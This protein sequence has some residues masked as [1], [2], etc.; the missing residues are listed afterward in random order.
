MVRLR[1]RAIDRRA[2]AALA[3]PL[4]GLCRRVG[5]ILQAWN[6]RS[7]RRPP[8]GE[9]RSRAAIGGTKDHLAEVESLAGAVAAIV[10][11]GC[12]NR[13]R[14]DSAPAGRSSCGGRRTRRRRGA[15]AR[16]HPARVRRVPPG[17][18]RLAGAGH[19]ARACASAGPF[20]P[21]RWRRTERARQQNRWRANASTTRARSRSVSP[22]EESMLMPPMMATWL[23]ASR[24]QPVFA[25]DGHPDGV[26]RSVPPSPG[27]AP[28]PSQCPCRRA[29]G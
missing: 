16:R 1:P 4:L 2:R 20:A 28:I 10:T 5:V 21:T 8:H 7:G 13:D 26:G 18:G 22:A 23:P 29:P 9:E 15:C 19:E 24:P 14:T 17:Q 6:Q 25:A 27:R 12:S 11:S 3:D